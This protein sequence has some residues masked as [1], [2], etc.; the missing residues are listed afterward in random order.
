MASVAAIERLADGLDHPE[1]IAL[2]TDGMLYAGGEAGQVYRVDPAAGSVEQIAST[3]GFVLG[4]CL[5]AAGAIYA[6]DATLAAVVRIDPST[7][8]VET[9]CDRAGGAPLTCPNWPAFAP[10]GSLVVSDSGREALNICEGT[11]FRVPRGGG[12]AEVLDLRPLHLSNGLAVT[13]KG[14]IIVLESL[15]PRLSRI[16]PGGIETIAELPGTT[17]DGVALTDDGGYLVSCYYPYRILHVDPAGNVTT[18]LDDATGIHIP[19]PT[20]MAFYGEGMTRLAIASLGGSWLSAIETPF[21]GLAL[22]YP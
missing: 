18:F 22:T 14:E 6:C 1:G 5:D 16:V 15:T 3:G 7:G 9:Y 20:N 12:E 17:P 4:L 8:A 2:G 21:R 10:D 11:V 13:P 19:M